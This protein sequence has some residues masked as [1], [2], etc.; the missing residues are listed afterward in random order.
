MRVSWA[1]WQRVARRYQVPLPD[2]QTVVMTDDGEAIGFWAWVIA[3][4]KI[5]ITI[6]EGAKKAGALLSTGRVAIAL[7]G[8]WNWIDAHAPRLEDGRRLKTLS[9]LLQ[10]FCQGNREFTLAFDQDKKQTTQKQV[11]LAAKSLGK[12]LSKAGQKVTILR[13]P[14]DC[15]KGIDDALV[16]C[17]P[18]WVDACYKRRLSLSA[19]LYH[20]ASQLTK[21]DRYLNQRY[22][23]ARDLTDTATKIL[24]IK[25]P[26]GTGKTEA[27][28]DL[29][30]PYLARGEEI[31]LISHREQLVKTLSDR[32]G[33]DSVYCYRDSETRGLLGIGL[34]ADSL[35][36]GGLANFTVEDW[37]EAL[38]IVDECEQVFAHILSAAT[39]VKNHRSEVLSNLNELFTIASRIILMDADLSDRSLGY[40]QRLAGGCSQYVIENTYRFQNRPI[41][42]HSSQENWLATLE[43]ALKSGQKVLVASDSQKAQSSY[44]TLNLERLVNHK[45]PD[46]STL[47]I[48]AE[49]IANPEHPAY[50]C[51]THLNELLGAYDVVFYSPTLSSGISL[52]IKGHFNAVFGIASGTQSCDVFRQFIARLRDAVPRH[53][54]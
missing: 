6:V 28:A 14:P 29:I 38:V 37:D 50:N 13:W 2:P 20:S 25:S 27:I 39:E 1:I 45:F 41:Y 19:W 43:D 10:A 31:I 22:L 52:D 49:T 9:T 12:A 23:N 26:K 24:A 46:L 42:V 47:R 11:R 33:V 54:L 16:A 5:P 4:P 40:A 53:I 3:N 35:R 21:V 36:R 17:G 7:P 15:G 18:E 8:I 44:G 48:D 30:A 34:C 32:F 51:I